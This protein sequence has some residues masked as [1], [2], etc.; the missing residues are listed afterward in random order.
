MNDVRSGNYRVNCLAPNNIFFQLPSNPLPPIVALLTKQMLTGAVTPPSP[1]MLAAMMDNLDKLSTRGCSEP[2]IRPCL[3][4]LFTT[5]TLPQELR[6]SHQCGIAR[7]LVPAG[8][9]ALP[10]P[11]PDMLYGYSTMMAF[12]Q[13]QQTTLRDIHPSILS[14]ALVA[15][16]NFPFFV[17]ELQAAAGTRGNLWDT[18]NECAGSAAACLQAL[19]QLNTAL[20]AAGCQGRIPNV[21]YCL[22][23]DNNLGQLYTSW[24]DEDGSKVHVQRVASYLLSDTEHFARLYACVASI[25]KWGATTRLQDIRMAADYIGRGGE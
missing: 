25:L 4:G 9:P 19:D 5:T 6:V 2:E 15:L 13:A 16:V 22:A 23:I 7:Y 12:T 17:I 21:C 11:F 8:S 24:K 20:G 1:A 3:E 18:A 10:Q 14:Y